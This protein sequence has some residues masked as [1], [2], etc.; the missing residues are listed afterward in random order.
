MTHS[1]LF[2]VSY[3]VEAALYGQLT[4]PSRRVLNLRLS[5]NL[6][7][8]LPAMLRALVNQTTHRLRHDIY[9]RSRP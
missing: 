3:D 4:I 2:V 6:R 5:R 7:Y 8:E 1:L 9:W